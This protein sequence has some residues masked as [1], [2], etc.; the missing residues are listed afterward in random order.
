MSSYQDRISRLE[1]SLTRT[2]EHAA[3]AT[4]AAEAL[5]TAI[6]LMRTFDPKMFLLNLEEQARQLR[7]EADRNS[8]AAATYAAEIAKI[9][10][11]ISIEKED[12]DLIESLKETRTAKDELQTILNAAQKASFGKTATNEEDGKRLAFLRETATNAVGEI[13]SLNDIENEIIRQLD[14]NT[15][16]RLAIARTQIQ[17]LVNPIKASGEQDPHWQ[18]LQRKMQT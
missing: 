14:N 15:D 6:E 5:E 3:N 13:D 9:E 4:A 17:I 12:D 2:T 8:H 10:E 7:E 18:Q 1:P 11:L 16:R